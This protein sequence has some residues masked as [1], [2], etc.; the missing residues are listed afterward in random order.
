MHFGMKSY[1]K[2]THNH[3]AKHALLM[4][5]RMLMFIFRTSLAVFFLMSEIVLLTGKGV[6]FLFYLGV[7]IFI[8]FYLSIYTF[9]NASVNFQI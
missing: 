2:S 1:L 9:I 5:Y 4:M 3:I 7:C 8:Y 6:L